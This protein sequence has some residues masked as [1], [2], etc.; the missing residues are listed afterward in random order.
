MAFHAVSYKPYCVYAWFWTAAASK[1]IWS[2]RT[3]ERVRNLVCHL[4]VKSFV[5]VVEREAE[6]PNP[7]SARLDES[8]LT[9]EEVEKEEDAFV[10]S[11]VMGFSTR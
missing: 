7:K 1:R 11:A 9:T 3:S 6:L 8:H 2:G 10:R 5:V 4:T